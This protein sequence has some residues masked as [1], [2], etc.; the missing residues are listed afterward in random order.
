MES[1]LGLLQHRRSVRQF[2]NEPVSEKDRRYLIESMLRAPSSRGLCPW[3]FVVVDQKETIEF[4]ANCKPH[5][6]TFLKDA[7]LAIVI[8]ADPEKCDVWIEDVSVAATIVH[9]AA[10]DLGLGSCWVQV[11]LRNHGD[12]EPAE[13][14][15]KKVLSIPDNFHVGAIIG[16]GYPQ[17][18]KAGHPVDSLSVEKVHYNSF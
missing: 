5:G 2:T 15:V 14:Y 12:G 16:I 4:L 13:G 6:A 17:A 9:L 8:C 10:T 18:L 7:P 1:F 11:R 3:E